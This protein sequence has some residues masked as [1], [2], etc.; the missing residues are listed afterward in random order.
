MLFNNVFLNFLYT[1]EMD[2]V[3][4]DAMGDL[5][6]EACHRR[7]CFSIRIVDTK[8]V[9]EEE[10]FDISLVRNN[11]LDPL[12][13]IGPRSTTTVTIRDDDSKL[14]INVLSSH[15]QLFPIRSGYIWSD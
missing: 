9:E 4:Q 15:D 8:E 7:Q 2:Y 10:S 13:Q 6:I 14:E 1:D 12:I 5:T 11:G 3:S